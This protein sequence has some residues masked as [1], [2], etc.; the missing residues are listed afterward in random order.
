[1][2]PKVKI[3]I[4]G[5][6]KREGLRVLAAANPEEEVESRA[7]AERAKASPH[8]E[9]GSNKSQTLCALPSCRYPSSGVERKGNMSLVLRWSWSL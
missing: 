6:L 9:P 7:R 1:M 2:Y 4:L 5:S 8:L 3:N